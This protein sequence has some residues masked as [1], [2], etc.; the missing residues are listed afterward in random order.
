MEAVKKANGELDY[1][2]VK[3]V[4]EYKGE[5]LKGYIHWVSKNHSVDAIVRV[6]NYLFTV[7]KPDDNW[8]N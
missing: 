2:K 4:P 7:E 5:K 6:Y 1:V 3:A 8:F